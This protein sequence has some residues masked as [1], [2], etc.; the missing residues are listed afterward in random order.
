VVGD[1]AEALEKAAKDG[2]IAFIRSNNSEFVEAAEKLCA[3]IQDMLNTI[4]QK[5]KPIK[6]KPERETLLKLLAA[7]EAF[8]M[9][10][11]D[12]AMEEIETYDYQGDDGLAAWLRENVALMNFRQIMEKLSSDLN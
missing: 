9:D 4:P 3:D 10:G 1:K 2:N 11:V 7:C 5:S 12:T 8:D 6:D